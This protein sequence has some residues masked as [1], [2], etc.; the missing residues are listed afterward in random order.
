[1]QLFYLRMTSEYASIGDLIFTIF[2]YPSCIINRLHNIVTRS[3]HST[4][5]KALQSL[6]IKDDLSLKIKT[7]E[8]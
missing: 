5:S 8:L 2:N 6:N 3:T 7:Y 1:M 4:L